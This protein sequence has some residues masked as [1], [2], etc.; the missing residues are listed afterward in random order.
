MEKREPWNEVL[1]HCGKTQEAMA[2]LSGM[3][4]QRVSERMRGKIGSSPERFA[5]TL[6]SEAIRILEP[7]AIELIIE[8]AGRII[9][10]GRQYPR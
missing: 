1:K 9:C 7:K 4:Q 8:R 3:T 5:I 10:D 6:A 2:L